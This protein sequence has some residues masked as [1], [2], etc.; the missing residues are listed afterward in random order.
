MDQESVENLSSRHN[1]QKFG[2]MNQRSCRELSRKKK[3]GSIERESI[4]DLS[5]LKK[6][7]FFKRGKIHKD[8]CNK[9]ATQPK[10]QSTC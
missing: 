9:Q 4:E 7:E 5:S 8:E 2:L 3:E 10:I 6:K 1:A